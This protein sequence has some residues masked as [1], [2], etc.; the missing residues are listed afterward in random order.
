MAG[1]SCCLDSRVKK[2]T[3]QFAHMSAVFTLHPDLPLLPPS[4]PLG[5]F[6]LKHNTRYFFIVVL[7]CSETGASSSDSAVLFPI[8]A[9]N[10]KTHFQGDCRY[11]AKSQHEY[12][13]CISLTTEWLSYLQ[14][15]TN[16][17]NIHLQP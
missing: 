3:A 8:Y 6:T 11:L 13:L 17:K 12:Q 14:L 4:S 5:I 9:L 2:G 10:H 16:G 7:R 15:N 1:I